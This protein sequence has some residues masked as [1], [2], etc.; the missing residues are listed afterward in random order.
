V[1]SIP[2]V[3]IFGGLVRNRVNARPAVT[4]ITSPKRF[5]RIWLRLFLLLSRQIRS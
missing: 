2:A 4:G 5:F 3:V 1:K